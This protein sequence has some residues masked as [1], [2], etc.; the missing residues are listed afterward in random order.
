[1]ADG[2]WK[3]VQPLTGYG[4]IVKYAVIIRKLI[5]CNVRSG[6]V[7]IR[8]RTGLFKPLSLNKFFDSS[9]PS[10]RKGRDGDKK[11]GKKIMVKIAAHYRRYQS[12]NCSANRSYQK[13]LV[14]EAF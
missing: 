8:Y 12:T 2:V 7:Q 3:W 11:N 1:M 6:M 4:P 13:H 10:M 9:N 14:K 5:Y